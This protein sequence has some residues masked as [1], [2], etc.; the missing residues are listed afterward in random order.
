MYD[1]IEIVKG[2]IQFM[3]GIPVELQNLTFGETKLRN[4]RAVSDYGILENSLLILKMQE[5]RI[6]SQRIHVKLNARKIITLHVD[7]SESIYA[8]KEKIEEEEGIHPDQ[9]KLIFATKDLDND[10]TLLEC[11]IKNEDT[12]HLALAAPGEREEMPIL[13]KMQIGKIICLNVLPSDTVKKVKTHILMMERIWVE[14]QTLI[15]GEKKL[16]D[17]RSLMSYGIKEGSTL[18]LDIAPLQWSAAAMPAS[19]G[20]WY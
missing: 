12:L 13:V 6:N 8:V 20:N 15:F 10:Y 14:R 16:E 19:S 3:E 18:H 1:T 11:G 5:P 17:G 7:L 4:G 9:Q 2:M